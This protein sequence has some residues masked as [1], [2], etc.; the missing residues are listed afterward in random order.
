METIMNK[1]LCI[2][3]CCKRELPQE[4]F[5]MNQRTRTTDN[6]CKECRKAN[7]RRHRNQDKSILFENKSVSYPVITEVKDYALRMFLIRHARQVVSDSIA[8]SRKRKTTRTMGR[9]K[10]G[11]DYFPMSTSFMHDRIVRRVMK[12]GKVMPLLPHW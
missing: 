7:A 8:R 3:G 6:Y 11:L 2:C 1:S 9:I 10:Q 5:Y 4:A 12:P